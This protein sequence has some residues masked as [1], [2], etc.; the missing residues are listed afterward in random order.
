MK[1]CVI[2]SH[3][4]LH[5]PTRIME[6]GAKRGHEMYLTTWEDLFINISHPNFY[7]GDSKK[8]LDYFDAIIPRSDRYSMQL[9]KGRITR[10]MNTLFRLVLEYAKRNNI[11]FLNSP[12]FSS[13]QSLDKMTQQFFFYQNDL[14]GIDT[15]Y[16]SAIEKYN[17]KMDTFPMVAKM[18]EGSTGTS[19]F[20][21]N[22]AEDINSFIDKCNVEGNFFIFQKFHKIT[23]D[24]RVIVVGNKVLGIMKRLP[25]NGEWR[26][27]FSL[28]GDVVAEENDPKMVQLSLDI[29]KKMGFDYVGID[30]LKDGEQLHI[31]ETNSLPQFKGFEKAFP[32]INVAEEIIKLVEL[33]SAR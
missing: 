1:I 28:G 31:I 19:V 25:K 14:P 7:F 27:N 20:K 16:F 18:A 17:K 2:S 32:E 29:A 4:N 26:T 30:L 8:S 13:Y 12:Y 33:K 10:N 9:E 15:S 22:N 24:F 5:A 23:S 6:E 21:V 11:F 3:A